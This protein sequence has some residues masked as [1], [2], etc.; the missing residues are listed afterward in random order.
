M[1]AVLL[2][3]DHAMFREALVMALAHA[4]PALAVHPAASGQEALALLDRHA[5]IG[6]VIMDYYL[7]DMAGAELLKRLRQRR[8]R[9]GVPE[10]IRQLPGADRRAGSDQCGGCA[11]HAVCRRHAAAFA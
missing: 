8:R 10:Q 11:S 3:D 5:D 9:A 2:I 7:P 6:N 1:N 4:M